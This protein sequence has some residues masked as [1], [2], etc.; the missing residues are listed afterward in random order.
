MNMLSKIVLEAAKALIAVTTCAF[1][2]AMS[3]A[4]PLFAQQISNQLDRGQLIAQAPAVPGAQVQP[5]PQPTGGAPANPASQG[6]AT[7]EVESLKA[8]I[9]DNTEQILS[10]EE[11]VNRLLSVVA[12][13]TKVVKGATEQYLKDPKNPESRRTL[14]KEAA[15]SLLRLTDETQRILN[16]RE[17]TLE[18][19]LQVEEKTRS[20]AVAY[21]N[22]AERIDSTLPQ[23]KSQLD[24]LKIENNTRKEQLKSDPANR[25][26]RRKLRDA[27]NDEIRQE[28]R[29][30][31][32][33][34]RGRLYI[35]AATKLDQS[36]DSIQAISDGLSDAFDNIELV[37]DDSKTNA[38][39]LGTLIEIEGRVAVFAKGT[40]LVAL[41]TRI[42]DLTTGTDNLRI[43]FGKTVKELLTPDEQGP[44]GALPTADSNFDRWLNA[45]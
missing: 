40:N 36:A 34:Q 42:R 45:R 1:T 22:S 30:K 44:G 38:E 16:E 31:S 7:T 26:L 18:R 21:R 11:S 6:Q 27:Y 28:M 39:L 24:Q 4:T 33:E 9:E 2:V 35:A 17:T 15:R 13:E 5:T 14:Q 29:L 41:Q 3:V 12:D 19:A 32:D 25:E 43:Q 8:M 10:V 23:R 37:H 20:E